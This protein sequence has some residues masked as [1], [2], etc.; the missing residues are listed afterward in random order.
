MVGSDREFRERR[1]RDAILQ[2]ASAA[3]TEFTF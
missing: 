1:Y 3:F 2:V